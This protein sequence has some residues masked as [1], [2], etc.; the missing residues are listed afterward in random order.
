[1]RTAW[2]NSAI[3]IH[4]CASGCACSWASFGQAT[5]RRKLQRSGILFF[6]NPANNLKYTVASRERAHEHLIEL[7]ADPSPLVRAAA[8]YALGRFVGDMEK[9]DSVTNFESN[10]GIS[11]VQMAS[12]ASPL[13]RRELVV[14]LSAIVHQYEPEYRYTASQLLDEDLKRSAS[15]GTPSGPASAGVATPGSASGGGIT[16]SASQDHLQSPAQMKR[17]NTIDVVGHHAGVFPTTPIAS[18]PVPVGL[19]SH[20]SVYQCIW[21]VV[22]NL[23]VDPHAD[24]AEAAQAVVDVIFASIVPASTLSRSNSQRKDSAQ[25]MKRTSSAFR[26][27]GGSTLGHSASSS[28]LNAVPVAASPRVSIHL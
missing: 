25:T 10:I 7:F 18:Q 3:T 27:G 8:V 5:A 24:V 16:S 15:A 12:D 26:F 1:M 19:A 6:F 14:A 23:S 17:N 4:N 13:V 9:K 11:L 21:K 28:S 20:L 2:P 22:L